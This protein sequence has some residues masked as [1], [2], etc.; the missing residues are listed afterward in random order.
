MARAPENPVASARVTY[1]SVQQESEVVVAIFRTALILLAALAAS[2]GVAE[3]PSLAMRA[4]VLGALIYNFVVIYLALRRI[5]VRGQRQVMVLIDI[6]LVTAWIYFTWGTGPDK[7]PSPL[8]PFYYQ[9]IIMAALWFGVRGALTGTSL[10]A[11]LY[12]LVV[13]LMNDYDAMT[14]VDALYR[15]IVYLF[16]AALAAGYVVDTHK[17]EREQWTRTQVLLAQYQ[18]RFRAAQEVYELLIPAQLP[19]IPGLEIAA[20]WRPALQEG[21]GDFYDVIPLEHGRVVITIADVSGKSVRGAIK[22]PLFKAAFLATAQ[23]WDDPGQVLSQVNRIVYPLLQPEMFITACV[24]MID[25]EQ[26]RLRYASA[27]QDPPVYLRAHA[28]EPVLLESGGLVLGIDEHAVYPMEEQTL[29]PGDTLCLYTD[30]ITEARHP[31][32]GEFGAQNLEAR[33]QAGVAVGLSAEAIVDNIFEAVQQYT[34][35]ERHRDDMT[36][37]VARY[38]PEG[39]DRMHEQNLTTADSH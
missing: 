25:L 34:R 30:G 39:Q 26:R 1:H 35:G 14:L 12:L 17:R 9:I 19:H 23:V 36:L 5:R 38:L 18:E 21:G 16:L 11:A 32:E 24:I 8:F 6:L 13:A 22:L 33:V 20:R 4:S 15:Q 28:H 3:A 2:L 7:A 10:I 27:G 29:E 31:E 37:L